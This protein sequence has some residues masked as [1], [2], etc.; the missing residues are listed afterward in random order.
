M[1]RAYE[2]TR[3]YGAESTLLLFFGIWIFARLLPEKPR[4][5]NFIK[6]HAH[7]YIIIKKCLLLYQPLRSKTGTAP[8]SRSR[9]FSLRRSDRTFIVFLRRVVDRGRVLR[10]P[11]DFFFCIWEWGFFCAKDSE[12]R[13]EREKARARPL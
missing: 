10:R 1:Q 2:N 11:G 3:F 4:G 9:K 12:S 7:V 5:S 8:R 6:N 13:T